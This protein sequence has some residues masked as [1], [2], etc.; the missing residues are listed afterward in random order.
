MGQPPPAPPLSACII[1]GWSIRKFRLLA[2]DDRKLSFVDVKFGDWPIVL[3][4][5][6]KDTRYMMESKENYTMG[7]QHD[8]IRVLVFNQT[9]IVLVDISVDGK[10]AREARR[11]G[12]GPLY[13]VSWNPG[14]FSVGLHYLTVTVISQGTIHKRCPHIEGGLTTFYLVYQS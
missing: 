11:Q 13:V 14:T 5:Y 10:E 3:V 6:P 8:M 7:Y 1:C 9:R 12:D 2:V 4:T